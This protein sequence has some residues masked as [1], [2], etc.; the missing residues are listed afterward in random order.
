MSQGAMI[1]R[2]PHL[3]YNRQMGAIQP[4]VAIIGSFRQHYNSVMEAWTAF[5]S[6]GIS[7][8]SPKGAPVLQER[9]RFVRFETDNPDFDDPHVQSLALHRIMRADVVLV[10]A[11]GGYVG[12]TTCY[13]IGRVIQALRPLYFTEPPDDVPIRVDPDHIV[14]SPEL[15]SRLSAGDWTPQPLVLLTPAG[16]LERSLLMELSAPATGSGRSR[17]PGFVRAGSTTYARRMRAMSS[18]T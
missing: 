17:P 16:R 7:V 4:S 13:E 12:R 3:S 2:Y 10:V 18:A 8:T 11:P 5:A 9:I 1:V 15:A 14:T 6:K